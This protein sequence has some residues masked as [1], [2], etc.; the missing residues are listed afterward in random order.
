M[1]NSFNLLGMDSYLL[2]L[3]WTRI[4]QISLFS[5]KGM[6]SILIKYFAD[7]INRL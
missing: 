3:I 4:P 6:D 2:I 5:Y 1:I 7:M